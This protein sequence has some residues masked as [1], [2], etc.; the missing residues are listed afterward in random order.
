MEKHT[1]AVK[2]TLKELL[3]S[4]SDHFDLEI[5]ARGSVKN[6]RVEV[7]NLF[8]ELNAETRDDTDSASF[9]VKMVNTFA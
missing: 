7:A 5:P 4:D 8:G 6:R 1:E 9:V 3:L 2:P